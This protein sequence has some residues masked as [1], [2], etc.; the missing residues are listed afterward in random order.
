MTNVVQ[1]A[2]PV[3]ID[4][5]NPWPGLGSFD[6]AAERFFNGR[7]NE[8]AELRRMV[9]NA[10]LTVLFGASGLGKTS[11]VKAGLFPR[12]RKEHY[13]PVYVRLDLRDRSAPLI[14]QAKLVL[15]AECEARRVDSPAMRDDESLWC[16]LHRAGLELWSEHNQLLTPVFVFDQF[17]EVFTLG[18]E[19]PAAVA[20]LRIDL[21]DL[22]ENRL[23]TALAGM[24]GS[25]EVES[26]EAAAETLSLDNQDYK[27]LLSFREDF[28]PAAE[29]W[30]RELPSILRNR[31]RL[32]PMSAARAFEAVHKTAPH[33]VSE[34]LARKIV[35][36]VA[37]AHENQTGKVISAVSEVADASVEPALLSLVCSG[38]NEKRKAQG[39]AEFDAELLAGS[40]QSIISDYYAKSVGDLPE[41]AQR[42]IENELITE[43]G[44]RKHCDIDDARSVHGVTDRELR[45][46]VDRRVLRLEPQ[47]GTEQVELTHD[48][49]TPVV[50]EHRERQRERVKV[51][52]QRARMLVFGT[53]GA[54]LAALVV[55]FAVLYR[56]AAQEK[57]EAQ[58][59][60][61][62]AQQAEKLAYEKSEQAT[63]SEKVALQEKER[64]EKNFRDAQQALAAA[65]VEKHRAE[66]ASKRAASSEQKLRF[67]SLRMRERIMQDLEKEVD[68]SSNLASLSPVEGAY[69]WHWY[70]GRALLEQGKLPLA[71]EEAEIAVSEA[72]DSSITRSIRGYWYVLDSKPAKALG[73][74]EYVEKKIDP[75][76]SLNQVELTIAFALLGKTAEARQAIDKAID[77]FSYGYSTGA[78]ELNVSPDITSATGRT[79]LYAGPDAMRVALYYERALLS[80]YFGTAD[81]AAELARADELARR[82][83]PSNREDGYL[84]AFNWAY[85]QETKKEA[86]QP[87]DYGAKA[88]QAALWERVGLLDWAAC[89]YQSFDEQHRRLHDRRYDQL[90]KWAKQRL[91]VLG[92][93]APDL[94]GRLRSM[95]SNPRLLSVM[96]QQKMYQ[97]NYEEA[98]GIL[99]Q[100]I[101]KQPDNIDL[102]LLRAEMHWKIASTAF[103][104]L[105][106][107]KNDSKEAQQLKANRTQAFKDLL[108]D[109][110]TIIKLDPNTADAY[111]WRGVAHFLLR[112][113]EEPFE[114]VLNDCRTALKL[115]VTHKDALDVLI[116]LLGS[117]ERTRR[118]ALR[119]AEDYDR[120]YPGP[121][122]FGF[123][124]EAKLHNQLK[125]YSAA[126]GAIEHAIAIDGAD[127]NNYDLRA[128]SERG[129]GLDANQVSRRLGEGYLHAADILK[130]RGKIEEANTAYEKAWK[131]LG[132]TQAS[133][134]QAEMR[135]NSG[136]T[137]CEKIEVV[138]SSGAPVVSVI[139]ELQPGEGNVRIV[140]IER[141]S[142]D[143]LLPGVQGE[144]T[145]S[146]GKNR[147][148]RAEVLSVDLHSAMVEIS[149]D[150][151]FNEGLTMQGD[152]VR[153]YAP[154][155]R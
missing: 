30:K 83:M 29:G 129:L 103:Q 17:E 99:S 34:E 109:S 59:A 95:P 9:L 114:Q 97:E 151:L 35:D 16:Y 124:R 49:L 110:E 36:F 138:H 79:R 119:Y 70:K 13:L 48:L 22:I 19:N 81:F 128:E 85:W 52:R 141:G 125:E 106:T 136:A 54:V 84:L 155:P 23:P 148:G 46:L 117:D 20:Q 53:V 74:L 139:K 93:G 101:E 7:R 140:K 126:L 50:R 37:G 43:R 142:E 14:D 146:D 115:S 127:L 4:E 12:L 47:R 55:V 135:C 45:L 51:R 131:I 67:E 149:T 61:V 72:P 56:S 18:A 94:C 39:K 112:K 100:A 65:T 77:Y 153:L 150:K 82:I 69:L 122:D 118:E 68:L 64:A 80:S 28:L 32:L 2:I 152:I 42:F 133:S 66:E 89:Y 41:R 132:A 76:S 105:S 107:V 90:A 86:G 31:L 24:I 116:Y 145:A 11:L 58:S 137:V 3:S 62:S 121:F 6:E 57:R 154:A 40:G 91:A 38:L 102:L 1:V 98:Q 147:L 73:D 8:S 130:Q 113:P 96:A 87:E 120:L 26:N 75:H 134:S 21:A 60:R 44:F 123:A 63:K 27:V 92:Q 144:I 108:Q 25:N 88:G 143:G 104:K 15:Q 111:F 10:P 71:L 5:Q 33:L 78:Q